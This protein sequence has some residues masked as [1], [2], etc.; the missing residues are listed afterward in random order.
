[1]A[2][3]AAGAKMNSYEFKKAKGIMRICSGAHERHQKE[4]R[5]PENQFKISVENDFQLE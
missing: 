1:M 5:T 4:G 2:Y 3:A